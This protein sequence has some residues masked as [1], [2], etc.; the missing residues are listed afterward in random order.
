[1]YFQ[2]Q[3]SREKP[4]STI[5]FRPVEQP[6]VTIPLVPHFILVE[7]AGADD[8]FVLLGITTAQPA[9][10]IGVAKLLAVPGEATNDDVKGLAVRVEDPALSRCVRRDPGTDPVLDRSGIFPRVAGQASSL[11]SRLYSPQCTIGHVSGYE[12]AQGHSLFAS[13]TSQ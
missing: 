4:A 1:M 11:F 9:R 3:E 8:V 5:L 6:A 10:A 2:R 7:D 12:N 13:I